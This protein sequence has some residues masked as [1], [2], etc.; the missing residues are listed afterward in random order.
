[1]SE[2]YASIATKAR[3]EVLK[4]VH[5][6]FDLR[7]EHAQG[8]PLSLEIGTHWVEQEHRADAEGV[9]GVCEW[10]F[11]GTR[12]DDKHEAMFTVR[13]RYLVHYSR[14]EADEGVAIAFLTDVGRM[15][16]YPYFRAHVAVVTGAG[17]LVLPPL[18]T[19]NI[20]TF[21]KRDRLGGRVGPRQEKPAKES[22][23]GA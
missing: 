11:R 19:I 21:Q 3:L 16:I 15:A 18:P 23:A 1:M 13:A 2:A 20:G 10:L 9:V 5:S 6:E 17:G 14:V 7:P 12:D 4:L 22:D 8:E